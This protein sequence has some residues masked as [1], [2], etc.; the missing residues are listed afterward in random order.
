MVADLVVTHLGGHDFLKHRKGN[1]EAAAFVRARRTRELDSVNFRKQVDG[2]GEERLM[3]LGR[4]CVLEPAQR[5][6]TVVQA[7]PMRKFGPRKRVD[8]LYVM[9]EF[10]QLES[11]R[12]HLLDVVGLLYREIVPYVVDAT[13]GRRDDVIETREVAH[14]QRLGI[15]AFGVETAIGHW[16]AAA[17]LVAWIMDIVTEPLQKFERRDADLWEKGI[18]VTGD[19]KPDPHLVAP[20]FEVA[21]SHPKRSSSMRLCFAPAS[22]ISPMATMITQLLRQLLNEFAPS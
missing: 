16:L 14:E 5:T 2:F 8:F 7:D 20:G 22:T 11:P 12:T 6:A 1:A 15:G 19:E 3:Q 13:A 10:D 21:T 17:G 9:Q 18:N 4:K